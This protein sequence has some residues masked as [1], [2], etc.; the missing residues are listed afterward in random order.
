MSGRLFEEISKYEQR[1]EWILGR[2]RRT[3]NAI[4]IADGD[5]E[6]LQQFVM[7]L[8]DIF[9]DDQN[10]RPYARRI[11]LAY[12]QGIQNYIGSPSYKSVSDILAIVRAAKT[13]AQQSTKESV[14]GEAVEGL[15][16]EIKAKC[17][18]LLKSGALPQ[19]VELSFKIVRDRLRKLTT[20]ETA[21]EAFGKGKLYIAGAAA[22]NV[23]EDFNAGAKFLM[24]AIDRFRNEKSHTSEANIENVQHAVQYLVLSSL[25][26]RL[27]DRA[28]S[29]AE[30]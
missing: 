29:A 26:L 2:F 1:F 8:I 21:S 4:H 24:M 18:E 19:A 23:D 28:S 12:E 17:A 10:L 22:P 20:F 13:R 6:K 14:E 3:S 25:A 9:G 15:H 7:E 5:D 27:L 16:P 30:G 11:G